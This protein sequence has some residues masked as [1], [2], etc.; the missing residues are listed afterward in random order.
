MRLSP[1]QG[2]KDIYTHKSKHKHSY[3]D[4]RAHTH[5]CKYLF[6]FFLIHAVTRKNTLTYCWTIQRG[7]YSTMPTSGK[8]QI[9]IIFHLFSLLKKNKEM[10]KE[11]NPEPETRNPKKQKKKEKRHQLSLALIVFQC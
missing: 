3:T 4:T 8:P 11:E 5:T 2:E 6:F 9:N 1:V 10:L 7:L